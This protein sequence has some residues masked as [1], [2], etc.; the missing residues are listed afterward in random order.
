MT[1]FA[2][3]LADIE[4]RGDEEDRVSPGAPSRSNH[5]DR[6]GFVTKT[7]FLKR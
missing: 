4:D 5:A 3:Q 1:Y 6:K 2:A 7:R